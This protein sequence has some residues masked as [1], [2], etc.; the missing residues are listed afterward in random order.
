[1]KSQDFLQAQPT[2]FRAGEVFP[3]TISVFVD[4]KKIDSSISKLPMNTIRD[5]A[6]LIVQV[7]VLIA[8]ESENAR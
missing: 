2:N 3:R 1:M 5:F 4:E 8:R 7:P 6:G